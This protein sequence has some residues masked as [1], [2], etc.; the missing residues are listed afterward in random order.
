MFEFPSYLLTK[1][2]GS[3]LFLREIVYKPWRNLDELKN[4]NLKL[5]PNY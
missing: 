2:W 4:W 3:P 1:F 5:L